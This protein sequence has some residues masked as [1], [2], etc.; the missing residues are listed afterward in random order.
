MPIIDLDQQSA[1]FNLP[2]ADVTIVGAGAAGLAIACGLL[3]K[4]V[5]VL[6]VESGHHKPDPTREALNACELTGLPMGGAHWGRRR[7]IGGTTTA[8]GGQALPFS[9]I[10]FE[11]RPWI[12]NSGWPLDFSTLRPYYERA[13]R[14]MRLDLLNYD[15]DVF[16]ALGISDP[17]FEPALLRYH[18]A[19]WAPEPNFRRMYLKSLRNNARAYLVYS[20]NVVRIDLDSTL[21]RV[22]S[23][24]VRNFRDQSFQQA[25]RKLVLTVGGIE[26][27]RILL[28]NNHQLA[29]GLGNRSGWVGRCFMDHP[30]VAIGRI[31][32][33]E[34][35][36][37]QHLFGPRF[38]RGRRY[39][40]RLTLGAG[41]QRKRELANAS[42]SIMFT[43][44]EGCD[45]VSFAKHVLSARSHPLRALAGI[46]GFLPQLASAGWALARTGLIYRPGATAEIAL[47]VEQEPRPESCITLGSD[48]DQFGV[49]L[50]SIHW[51]YSRKTWETV[52]RFTA[53]LKEE[54]ERLHLGRV[55][56]DSR[57]GM[58]EPEWAALCTDVNHH[59][60]T[61]RM[62][63][64]A[65]AG[66]VTPNLRIHDLDNLFICSSAVFPT[67]SHSNPTLTILALAFRL[68]DHL[69]RHADAQKEVA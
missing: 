36:A 14:F 10:D 52:V 48:R 25:P 8:W 15:S 35:R 31:V 44:P 50:T 17:G 19:K 62:S 28:T 24:T 46:W 69:T 65:S 2:D 7:I 27:V 41:E 29:T 40:I 58:D 11:R 66:V 49:P 9:E 5:S 22:Q 33:R 38:S 42:A 21:T 59:M 55:E 63:V 45:P 39:S 43:Y 32:P 34:P 18:V 26:T 68:V 53:I 56:L 1:A 16:P 60:G 6:L 12:A 61:A 64:D 30:C 51:E 37:F 20:A 54:I 47:M 57:V 13:S 4:G 67:G 23:L 3:Q